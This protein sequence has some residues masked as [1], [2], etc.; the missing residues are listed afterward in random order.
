MTQKKAHEVDAFL[1]GSI[2][3]F[4]TFLVYGPD[5]GLVSTPVRFA[6]ATARSDTRPRSGP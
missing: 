6:M 2:D 4:A 3:R 5:R 1:K